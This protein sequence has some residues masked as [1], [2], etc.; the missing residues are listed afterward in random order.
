M[1]QLRI[2]FCRAFKGREQPPQTL[3]FVFFVTDCIVLLLCQLAD[4]ASGG[5]FVEWLDVQYLIQLGLRMCL[6]RFGCSLWLCD[7]LRLFCQPAKQVRD[8]LLDLRG[9]R[10][11]ADTL[12]GFLHRCPLWQALPGLPLFSSGFKQ[13]GIDQFWTIVRTGVFGIL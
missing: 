9:R 10:L 3:S 4:Q 5:V 8:L 7:A 2:E 11:G 6:C 12:E 1:K 13:Y